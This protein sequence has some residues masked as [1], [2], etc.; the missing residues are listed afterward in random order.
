MKQDLKMKR[1]NTVLITMSLRRSAFFL[2]AVLAIHVVSGDAEYDSGSR[3]IFVSLPSS[4]I[5]TSAT[6]FPIPIMDEAVVTYGNSIYTFA[7]IS[8]GL[9][10]PNSYRFDG[11]TWTAIAAYPWACGVEWPS[12]VS[13]GK[14]IYIMN[15]SKFCPFVY[16]TD[17]FR[18]DPNSDSY[19]QLASNTVGT[20]S[21][22]AV[23]LNGKIY[24]MGGKNA[25]G[26]QA[27]LEIYDIATDTWTFG[28]ALLQ[29][30]GFA[31][32]WTQNGFVYV[33]GGVIESG[34]Y[35]SK[36]YR[37]DPGSN[38]WDDSAIEDLPESR[39][40]AA[41][42]VYGGSVV[43]AGGYIGLSGDLTSSAIY[44]DSNADEWITLPDMPDARARMNGAA[45]DTGFY[46]IGGTA[47]PGD[48][49]GTV[50]NQKF[51]CPSTPTP[52]PTATATPTP[53]P[54][55]CTG[56]CNPTPRPHP[57]PTRRPTPAPQP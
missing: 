14:F 33:A 4:C 42:A 31:A 56:R 3:D 37:Y 50:I 34:V 36:T 21:Q 49:N 10:V 55:P 11:T 24:K 32:S 19:L 2:F 40:G 41:T 8:V 15:G 20:W 57:T 5:W 18:Y 16:S 22:T 27:V 46:A 17:L 39:W 30:A 9:G 54:T 12:A 28:A 29:P 26:Y 48:L 35:T 47:V 44:W 52:T 6:E 13:D 38:S 51:S 45:D 1:Q 23:Y 43:L 7:G 53:T 25:G